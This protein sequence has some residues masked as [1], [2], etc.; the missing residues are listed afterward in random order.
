MRQC[1]LFVRV[2]A[3]FAEKM[4]EGETDRETERESERE[5]ERERGG[6]GGN[7]NDEM[8]R[9]QFN[10]GQFFYLPRLLLNVTVDCVAWLAC[11]FRKGSRPT[12]KGRSA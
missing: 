10:R 1:S 3:I 12:E 4:K 8:I 9:A 6:G 5:R 7:E 2:H 11:C